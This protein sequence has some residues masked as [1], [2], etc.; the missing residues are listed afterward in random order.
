MSLGVFLLL[1]PLEKVYLLFYFFLVH[2]P[3]LSIVF[4]FSK[5]NKQTKQILFFPIFFLVSFSYIFVPVFIISLI[6]LTL[7][8]VYLFSTS[9]KY[10]IIHCYVKE[11]GFWK[12][13]QDG[14]CLPMKPTTLIRGLGHSITPSSFWGGWGTWRSNQLPIANCLINYLY[15]VKPP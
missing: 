12:V 3:S 7:C 8:F 6:L 2:P 14:G 9:L 4:I 5:T 10:K 11:L 1:Q 15:V 13:S